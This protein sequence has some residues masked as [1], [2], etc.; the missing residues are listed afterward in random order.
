MK[1]KSIVLVCLVV[2][3]AV[4]VCGQYSWAGLKGVPIAKICAF[5]NPKSMSS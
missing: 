4:L 2:I 5:G 1:I 3:V